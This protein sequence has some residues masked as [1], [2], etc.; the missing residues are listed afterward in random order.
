MSAPNESDAVIEIKPAS[1]WEGIDFAE[2]RRYRDLFYFLVLRDIKVLYAQTILGF[3]WAILN[4]AVQII[5]FSVI[6][7]RV[8]KVP[9]DGIPYVLFCTAAIIPWSYMSESM[10]QSSQSLVL[11]QRV[12]GKVYFPRIIFPL[13]PVF[14]KLLDFAISLLLLAA[15]L[16]YYGV[17][18]SWNLLWLPLFIVLMMCVPVGIGLWLSALAIRFR[19]VKFAM[20]YIIRLLI[21]TAPILYTAS[22]IPDGYR[23]VYSLNP[24]VGV[25]EG[26]RACLLGLPLAWE[27]ILPSFAMGVVF[28][29]AGAIYFRRME[30][31]FVD[32]I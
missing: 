26:F 10:I 9:T 25:I 1:G 15:V 19:D 28:V 32:V 22:S 3:A 2:L 4:P 29:A 31:V 12:L 24:I 20:S 30:R 8:A 13:T 27:Y 7:G 23:F 21:Y 16:L 14:A 17:A 6:F 5:L 11:Q 18:P